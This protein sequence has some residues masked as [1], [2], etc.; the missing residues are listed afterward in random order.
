MDAIPDVQPFVERFRALE[1]RMSAEDF[2]TDR[3]LAA[4]VG[5]EYRHIRELLESRQHYEFLIK[6]LTDAEEILND[7]NADGEMLL[8]AQEE[9]DK[10]QR[11]VDVAKFRVLSLMLPEDPSDSRNTVLE[12]RAG[13]GGD[14]A[15]IFAGDLC[16]MYV[17]FS[18]LR[19][20]TVEPMSSHGAELGGFKEVILLISGEDVYKAL[21]FESGVHRVQRIPETEANGRVHTST[22]TVA[23][24]P[25]AEEVDDVQINPED[26][27]ISICRASGAGGQH[28]NKTDSAVQFLHKPTGIIVYCADE[29][30]Q[31]KNRAKAMKVLRARLLEQKQREEEE[32]YA[33]T[34]RNQV[35]SGDRSE[36]IRTYNF[37]QNRL[38]DHRIC[39]TLYNLPAVMEGDLSEVIAALHAADYQSRIQALAPK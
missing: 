13:A 32:K 16:R 27:E 7:P 14:E 33:S 3:R 20:W 4:A 18:E 12:I 26:L 30:S 25:E 22:V 23:V 34:R 19:G 35:G 39:L 5:R 37:P 9:R 24:L 31:Q 10:A 38:T 8:W 28:V 11:Q 17:R 15:A 29:R 1:A 36:R 6:T 2:Y 21:K